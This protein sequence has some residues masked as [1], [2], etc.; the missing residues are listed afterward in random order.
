MGRNAEH[1]LRGGRDLS[2]FI[3]TRSAMPRSG[4][5][6]VYGRLP[7]DRSSTMT[8]LR[9][10]PPG[11][12]RWYWELGVGGGDQRIQKAP[13]MKKASIR[14]RDSRFSFVFCCHL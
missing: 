12:L 9:L 13:A 14:R 5:L 10:G 4:T 11:A 3:R 2:M 7:Q 1:A 6:F 8:G